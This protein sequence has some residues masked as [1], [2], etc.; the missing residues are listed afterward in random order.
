MQQETFSHPRFHKTWQEEKDRKRTQ[1]LGSFVLLS[2]R[3]RKMHITKP[4]S[5]CV[6]GTEN[7]VLVLKTFRDLRCLS[8]LRSFTWSSHGQNCLA[9]LTTLSLLIH[10]LF[11]GAQK[12]M[13]G[14]RGEEPALLWGTTFPSK[15][16]MLGHWVSVKQFSEDR[17]NF[18]MFFHF[19][20]HWE[21]W[22]YDIQPVQYNK[23]KTYLTHEE[24]VA[25][26]QAYTKVDETVIK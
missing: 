17:R 15:V 1:G 12:R 25:L 13:G 22:L 26:S 6:G 5:L 14:S 10:F 16:Q 11:I 3:K 21:L 24:K 19:L 7:V 20:E 18:M 2:D 8:T 23:S 9:H 4:K